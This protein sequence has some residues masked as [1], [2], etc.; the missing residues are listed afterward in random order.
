MVDTRVLFWNTGRTQKKN[1]ES[2]QSQ[3]PFMKQ[4]QNELHHSGRKRATERLKMWTASPGSC[5][6]MTDNPT[7]PAWWPC[8]LPPRQL[9]QQPV[10]A[11]K[12]KRRVYSHD[13]T[14]RSL[15]Q[16]GPTRPGRGRCGGSSARG[17]GAPTAGSAQKGRDSSSTSRRNLPSQGSTPRMGHID[18]VA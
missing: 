2:N 16:G 10:N 13:G 18:P 17:K 1:R 11:G 9:A 6:A 8:L 14:P 15:E 4:C 5:P 3:Y 7:C 12:Q